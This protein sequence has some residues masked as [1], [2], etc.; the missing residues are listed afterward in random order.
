MTFE[1]LSLS[2]LTEAQRAEIEALQKVRIRCGRLA[3]YRVALE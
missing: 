3:E 2:S 1:V